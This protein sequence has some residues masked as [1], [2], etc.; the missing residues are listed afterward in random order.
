M[1]DNPSNAIPVGVHGRQRVLFLDGW[2]GAAI[3]SVFV[4]H[5]FGIPGIQVARLGVELFFVLSG[6]LMAEI[7]FVERFPLAEFFKRRIARIWPALFVFVLASALIFG[8]TGLLK[9]DMLH[10][11]AA[12]TFTINYLGAPELRLPIYDHVWSLCIEEWAY[13]LLGGLAFLARGKTWDAKWLIA[14]LALACFVNGAVQTAL[15]GSY[16]EVY[17][18]TDVR[19]ASILAGAA[20]YLHLREVPAPPWLAVAAGLLG[21]GL[22]ASILPDALKYSAGTVCLAV[23][24]ATL[25][26]AYGWVR[27]ALSHPV[28]VRIGLW[29]F[30]LYLWQQPFYKLRE[31]FPKLGMLALAIACGLVSFYLVEQPARR[32]INAM[33]KSRRPAVAPKVA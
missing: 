21:V 28:I 6:R 5:Y 13:I 29:S 27:S 19:I 18:R 15:G 14:G 1:S 3:L 11:V 25:P 33:R 2:R 16:Y 17:W 10:I 4:G 20:V 26:S 7:L 32:W 23:S 8:L 12:L 30:S 9:V 24:V 22:N 31:Q